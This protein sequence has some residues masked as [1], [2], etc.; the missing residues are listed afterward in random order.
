MLRIALLLTGTS[1]M[2]RL[3]EVG[4]PRIRGNPTPLDLFENVSKT[5]FVSLFLLRGPKVPHA[6]TLFHSWPHGGYTEHHFASCDHGISLK[7]TMNVVYI[8]PN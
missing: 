6:A 8:I 5:I 1:D 2:H 3:A 4:R 7:R